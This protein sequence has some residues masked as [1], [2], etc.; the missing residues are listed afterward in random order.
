MICIFRFAGFSATEAEISLLFKRADSLFQTNEYQLAGIA[1]D[2]I[3]YMSGDNIITTKAL[4]KKADCYLVRK[5]FAKAEIVLSRIFYADL[6]DSLVYLARYKTALASYLNSDFGEAESQVIQAKSLLNDSNLVYQIYPLY[7]LILNESRKYEEAKLVLSEYAKHLV[8]DSLQ[9]LAILQEIDQQYENSRIPKLKNPEKAKKLSMFLPGTGQL[10][11]GYFWEGALNVT[12]QLAGLGFTALCIWQK[13]YFTGA[14]VG[15]SIFQ[16]FYGGGMNR[17]QFLAEKRNYL[18][19]R[20]FNDG[21]KTYMIE[22]RAL[23]VK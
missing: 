12:L 16:K 6:S 2:Q 13:Y 4:L 3:A 1:Y 11:A 22:N 7:V 9:R 14:F 19:T 10:Y 18:T 23:N 20:K 15:F 8:K 17:A 21:V 5:E